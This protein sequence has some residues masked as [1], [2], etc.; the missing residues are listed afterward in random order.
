[1]WF[2]VQGPPVLPVMVSN[3]SWSRETKSYLTSDCEKFTSYTLTV[4]VLFLVDH[5]YLL[6]F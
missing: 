6:T 3:L 4:F 1:M 5:Q 2:V